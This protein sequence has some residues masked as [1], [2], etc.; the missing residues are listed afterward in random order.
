MRPLLGFYYTLRYI[1]SGALNGSIRPP[2]KR[3]CHYPKNLYHLALL[4]LSSTKGKEEEKNSRDYASAAKAKRISKGIYI[5]VEE[6]RVSRW[7]VV[8]ILGQGYK[9]GG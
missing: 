4:N 1:R 7:K 3:T 2:R 8:L 6:N 9:E 5:I